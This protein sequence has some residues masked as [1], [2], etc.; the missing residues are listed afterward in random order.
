MLP[1]DFTWSPCQ[2]RIDRPVSDC[3][4]ASSPSPPFP[5]APPGPRALPSALPLLTRPCAAFLGPFAAVAPLSRVM[6]RWDK[7]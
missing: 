5:V 3:S 4:P 1:V 2:N 7:R 6:S